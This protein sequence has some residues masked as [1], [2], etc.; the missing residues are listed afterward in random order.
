MKSTSII[1][2][3]VIAITMLVPFA[4]AGTSS[5]TFRDSSLVGYQSFKIYSVDGLGTHDLG[6]YNSTSEELILQSDV[7]VSTAYILQYVPTHTD[8]WS[9]PAI[10]LESFSGY[11]TT[12]YGSW[13]AIFFLALLA[14]LAFALARRT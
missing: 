12:H 13:L 4:S 3:L 5:L 11:V 14:A 7:N 10:G 8:F 6:L 9:D 2:L 1:L